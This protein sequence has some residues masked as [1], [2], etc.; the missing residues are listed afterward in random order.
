MSTTSTWIETRK[1]RQFQELVKSHDF[2]FKENPLILD[3]RTRVVVSSD[4]LAPGAGRAF[5]QEWERMTT[6]IKETVRSKSLGRR[7]LERMRKA[8]GGWTQGRR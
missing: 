4:H 7:F 5:W 2:R 6:E 1:L 3:S 8:L